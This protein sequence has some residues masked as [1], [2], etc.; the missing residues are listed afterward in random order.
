MHIYI[1]AYTCRRP[2][3]HRFL[4]PRRYCLQPNPASVSLVQMWQKSF[5]NICNTP[6]HAATQ[7]EMKLL[8]AQC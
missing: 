7:A 3:S 5:V 6:Q 2:T 8:V 4:R 1:C